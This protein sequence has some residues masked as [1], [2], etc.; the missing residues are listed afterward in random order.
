MNIL[1]IIKVR[2]FVLMKWSYIYLYI[3]NFFIVI[4]L[5]KPLELLDSIRY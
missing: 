1:L 5:K 4:I 3:Y 2:N